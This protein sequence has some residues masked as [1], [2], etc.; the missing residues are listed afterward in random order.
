MTIS[1]HKTNLNEL[2]FN[3]PFKQHVFPRLQ[4]ETVMKVQYRG[5]RFS[6]VFPPTNPHVQKLVSEDSASTWSLGRVQSSKDNFVQM[7]SNFSFHAICPF[8]AKM[9]MQ[10]VQRV[11][12]GCI[13]ALYNRTSHQ[14]CCCLLLSL[15]DYRDSV[16]RPKH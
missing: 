10:I 13:V 9:S 8:Y 1:R 15:A 7:R 2:H 4:S 5:P 11:S 3:A 14:G 6:R 12:P 16:P